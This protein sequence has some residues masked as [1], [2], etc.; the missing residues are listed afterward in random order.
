[1]AEKCSC[2]EFSNHPGQVACTTKPERD[3]RVVCKGCW[4]NCYS[5]TESYYA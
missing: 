1:M 5:K 4:T 2:L 3:G